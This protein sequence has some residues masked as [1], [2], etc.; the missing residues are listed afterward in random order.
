[1]NI[2]KNARLTFVR[3]IEM[4]NEV[5]QARHELSSVAL[6]FGVSP[7]TARKWVGRYLSDGESGLIDHSSRPRTSPGLDHFEGYVGDGRTA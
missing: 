7:A 3:R 2:H 4:V 5:I 1:M 6:R